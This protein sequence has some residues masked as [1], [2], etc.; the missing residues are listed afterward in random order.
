MRSDLTLRTGQSSL[1]DTSIST[2]LFY[3]NT[4]VVRFIH[5]LEDY[6]WHFR[7]SLCSLVVLTICSI[8]LVAKLAHS[9]LD[10]LD[11]G[12]RCSSHIYTRPLMDFHDLA[13][14]STVLAE[15]LSP[16]LHSYSKT[17]QSSRFINRG[18]PALSPSE[19]IRLPWLTVMTP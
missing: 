3:S 12:T 15:Y 19:G 14:L 13:R 4:I 8:F 16:P 1:K 2:F 9:K 17:Q 6:Q 18:C 7:S 5:C 11:C 10:S